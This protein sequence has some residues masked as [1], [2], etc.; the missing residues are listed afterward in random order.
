LDDGLNLVEAV[1]SRFVTITRGAIVSRPEGS[2]IGTAARL[3]LRS[4]EASSSIH[5]NRREN[6][7]GT[8]LV[9]F[10][11]SQQMQPEQIERDLGRAALVEVHLARTR[12]DV[13]N[14]SDGAATDSPI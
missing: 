10:V 8:R 14:Q 13:G 6:K 4:H 3:S 9:R 11:A 2:E 7:L 1:P 5:S 12:G